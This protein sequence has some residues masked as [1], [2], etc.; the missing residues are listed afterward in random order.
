MTP[1]LHAKQLYTGLV[2]AV[3]PTFLSAYTVPAGFRIILRSVVVR[4]KLTTASNHVYIEV[5]GNFV[6]TKVLAAGGTSGDQ[7]QWQTWVVAEPGQV[8]G[9]AVSNATGVWVTISGSIYYV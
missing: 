1:L 3:N 4:N 7:D 5:A 8:I 6:W 9:A 2:V